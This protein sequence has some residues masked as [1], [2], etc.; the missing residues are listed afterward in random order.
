MCVYNMPV[1]TQTRLHSKMRSK[2]FVENHKVIDFVTKQLGRCHVRANGAGFYC[3]RLRLQ[4][5]LCRRSNRM[6]LFL[7]REPT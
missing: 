6:L 3:L 2:W 1:R 7:T 5:P 4:I